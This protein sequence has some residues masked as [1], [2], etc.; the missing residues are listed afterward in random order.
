MR[1]FPVPAKAL[2]RQEQR[3][4]SQRDAKGRALAGLERANAED[5]TIGKYN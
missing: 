5:E 4:S 1:V 2:R 3:E